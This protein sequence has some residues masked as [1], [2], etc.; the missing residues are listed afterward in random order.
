MEEPEPAEEGEDSGR[1]K[2]LGNLEPD[3]LI[4]FAYQIASGMVSS[5]CQSFIQGGGGGGGELK[6]CPPAHVF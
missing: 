1:Y 3:D 4:R 5:I 2:D 6:L